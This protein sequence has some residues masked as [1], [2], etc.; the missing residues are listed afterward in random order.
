MRRP[1]VVCR[2]VSAVDGKI[3]GSVNVATVFDQSP[4]DRTPIAFT[5]L[6]AKALSGDGVWLHYQPK[7]II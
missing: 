1:F 6:E 3:D 7:N 4:C 2:T 5:L